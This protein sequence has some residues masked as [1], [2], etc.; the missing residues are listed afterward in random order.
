MPSKKVTPAAFTKME[1]R[2]EALE[3]NVSEVRSTLINVQREMKENHASLIAMLERY[4][5][6]S[7][8]VDEGSASVVV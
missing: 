1:A 4:L 7:K 2:V 5:G 8:S 6:K 3:G